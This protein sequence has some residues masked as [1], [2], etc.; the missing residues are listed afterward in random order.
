MKG[1][2]TSELFP[3]CRAR[4]EESANVNRAD[5]PLYKQV[6]TLLYRMES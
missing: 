6:E 2:D 1:E 3:Y 4:M 5:D